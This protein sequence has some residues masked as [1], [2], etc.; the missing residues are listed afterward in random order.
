VKHFGDI[1]QIHGDQVPV[2][3][4]ITGGSP[5]QDLS[6]AGKR[7]G[8][9]GERSGLFMD[10]IRIVKEMRQADV[11][12]GRSGQF[13]RPRY[14]VWENV[15]GAFSSNGGKDFQA[16]L[17]EIVKIVEAEVPDLSDAV[18]GGWTKSGLLYSEVG[19]WSV[20][21]RVHDA[22]FWGV[23]QRRKRIAL[24]ADFGG[25]S[26]PEILFE[27]KGLHWDLEPSGE[28]WEGTASG[29]EGSTDSAICLQ[30]N[31]IDRADTA[32]CN[33]RGWRR[34]GVTP[35]TQST[36]RECTISFQERAGNPGGGEVKQ[37]VRY[38]PEI[39]RAYEINMSTKEKSSSILC[40][41]DQGGAVMAVSYDVTGTL[42]AEMGGHPPLA[43]VY[44]SHG[45]DARYRAL[46]ETCETISAKYG[47]GGVMFP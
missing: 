22:Q 41:N 16:V 23:P 1:T 17:E 15:P 28:A 14:M 27:R 44:E 10:Q 29:A 36:D 13:I 33:G 2:V 18:Q 30:G 5:C 34:G 19:Q 20:A 6:V 46:G 40:L 38:V 4:V 8:L 47:L 42:R 12:R 21:W 35:S 45:Q 3:D 37:S 32:R 39:T 7:A 9:S 24:V 26:A 43:L 11:L 31:G 25:L